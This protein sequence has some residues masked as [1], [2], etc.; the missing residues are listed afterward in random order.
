MAQPLGPPLRTRLGLERRPSAPTAAASIVTA[1]A[2]PQRRSLGRRDGPRPTPPLDA[3]LADLSFAFLQ[4]RRPAPSLT[5]SRTVP[6]LG[7]RD[8]RA[9]RPAAGKHGCHVAAFSP[10]GRSSSS[11]SEDRTAAVWDA[12]TGEPIGPPLP[13]ASGRVI[14]VAFSP[15]GRRLI[16]SQLAPARSQIW[17]SVH[18][19]P[20]VSC[21]GH[22]RPVYA[23]GASAPTA[24]ALTTAA[25]DKTA[26]HLGR[27]H[28]Q[29]DRRPMMHD[30][31]VGGMAC[32]PDVHSRG[33]GQRR[34]R[35]AGSG[36][37]H[38]QATPGPREASIA[39]VWRVTF[40]PD[41]RFL[42]TRSPDDGTTRLWDL[43]MAAPGARGRRAADRSGTPR[44]PATDVPWPALAVGRRLASGRPPRAY[45]SGRH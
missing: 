12:A 34:R 4:P 23:R 41:G 43:A 5:D 24:A 17:D 40:S 36:T 2:G 44:S 10:D 35:R 37:P 26:R 21:T 6:G 7:R 13:P 42:S 38:G 16:A 20:V 18:G 25:D 1:S 15:D 9:D 8:G 33:R 29:A 45:R 32:S 11:S 19:Q 27:G 39:A 28:R 14:G 3:T 31:P 30:G 22:T